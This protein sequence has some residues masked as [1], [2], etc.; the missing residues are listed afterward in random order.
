MTK[1]AKK[2]GNTMISVIVVLI[3]ALAAASVYSLRLHNELNGARALAQT[4]KTQVI[5]AT[6][7]NKCSDFA[8]QF[9]IDGPTGNCVA[10]LESQITTLQ[11]ENTTLKNELITAQGLYSGCKVGLCSTN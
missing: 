3:C 6:N 1:Q 9:A 11:S 4:Y 8:P 2:T 10:Q 7:D 5:T